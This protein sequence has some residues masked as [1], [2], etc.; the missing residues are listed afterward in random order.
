M[1]SVWKT[2]SAIDVNEHVKKKGQF[3][4]LSWTWCWATIKELY[5]DASFKVHKDTAYSD[6]TYEVN[7]S[8][9][10]DGQRHKIWL[11]VM[12]NRNNAIAN[13][14]A[15]DFGDAKMRCLVKAA[16]FHGLGHYIYAGESLPQEQG[17]SEEDWDDF[18]KLIA[19][20][21][22]IDVAKYMAKLTDTKAQDLFNMAPKG[23]KTKFKDAVR[24]LMDEFNAKATG[25]SDELTQSIGDTHHIGVLISELDDPFLKQRVW[26][27]LSPV[28]Q[29][30]IKDI[31]K[32]KAA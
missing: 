12:D 4:Y 27:Q 17:A 30:Q 13:P 7:V 3:S 24:K 23:Q 1:N 21:K 10:I 19:T 6:G 26:A 22:A 32:E 2:L 29:Q 31:L 15:R 8:I 5:P 25:Y 16:A 9:T 14:N 18:L 11:P 28:T 20:G